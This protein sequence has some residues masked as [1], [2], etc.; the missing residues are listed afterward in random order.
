MLCI[1]FTIIIIVKIIFIVKKIT[2]GVIIIE[3][4]SKIKLILM[5]AISGFKLSVNVAMRQI[6]TNNMEAIIE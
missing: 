1:L 2:M 4:I 5:I 6:K 3:F